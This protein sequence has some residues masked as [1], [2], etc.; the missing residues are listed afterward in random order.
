M[1]MKVRNNARAYILNENNEI[2]L[3]KFEFSFIGALKIL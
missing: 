1:G 3:Q 2:L